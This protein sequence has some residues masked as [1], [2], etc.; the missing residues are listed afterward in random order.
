M[1]V[2]Y[3]VASKSDDTHNADNA[4]GAADADD[5]DGNYIATIFPGRNVVTGSQLLV[6]KPVREEG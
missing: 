2:R 5:A 3:E 6:E 1:C 4:D